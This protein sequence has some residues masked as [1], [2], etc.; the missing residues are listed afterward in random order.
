MRREKRN[1]LVAWLLFH[2]GTV[3]AL[4]QPASSQTSVATGN[5][6]IRLTV[7]INWGTSRDD[8]DSIT[9]RTEAPKR[10][11]VL[12]LTAG[13]LVDVIDWPPVSF[14]SDGDDADAIPGAADP[15]ARTWQLGTGA[16]GRVRARI[17][18]P[19]DAGVVMRAGDQVVN[20]PLVAILERPQRTPPQSDLM[21]SIE[22]LAWDSLT[23]D[24]GDA[25]RDGI[26]APGAQ[27]PV[28]VAYNIL[29][30]EP[31]DVSVRVS[32]VLR[33]SHGG[34]ALWRIEPR[35]VVAANQ[36]E[37]AKQTWNVRAPRVEGTYVLEVQASWEP[38]SAREGSR[39]SRLIRR[40]KPATFVSSSVRKVAFTVID[41]MAREAE[42]G[43]GRESEVDSIDLAK[44][45][46]YRPLAAGRSPA[47]EPGRSAWAIPPEALIEPSR[48]ERVRGWFMRNGVEASKLEPADGS[49]LAWTAV[50]LKVSHPD[51]PHRL[52]LKI[53]GGE[54]AALGVAVVEAAGGPSASSPRLLLDACASGPPIIPGG[55]PSAFNWLLWPGSSEMVLILVNRSTDAVVQ[56]GNVTVTELDELPAASTVAEPGPGGRTLGLYLSGLRSLD[57]FG[58]QAG[59]SDPFL[60]ARNLARYLR[61]C[62]ATAVVLPADL[63]DRS[64]RQSLDGQADED[65]TRPDRLETVRRVL[66]RQGYS[67]WLELGFDGF[68]SLPGLPPAGSAEALR[69]GLVRVDREGKADGPAYHPLHPQVKEAM[70]RKIQQTVASLGRRPGETPGQGTSGLL[71][72]L[73]PGPTL[74]GTPETGLDDSTFD[75]FVRETFKPETAR[76]IPGSGTTDPER[77]AVRS[78]FLAGVGRM[79]WM[80]WRTRAIAALYSELSEAAR[81][82]DPGLV[83]AVVTPGLDHGSSGSEARRID[84]AGLAPSQAW[85]SVGL[86]LPAWSS[87]PRG[88]PVL[89]GVSLSTD[90][91]ARDL[92]T[93]PDLDALV[94]A[95]PQRGLLLTIDT[96]RRRMGMTAATG[97][98]EDVAMPATSPAPGAAA[99]DAG[100]SERTGGEDPNRS[101]G[102]RNAEAKIWLTALPLGDGATADLPLGH[103]IAALDAQWMFLE[104]KAV[105]G[106]EERVRRFARVLRALP[107]RS[108]VASEQADRIAGPF[109]VTA[110]RLND[111]SQTFLEIANDSPYPV[112]VAGVLE[113]PESTV[114]EDLGRGLRLLPA[115]EAGERKLVFDLIP[116]GVAAIRVGSP[117]ARLT[118]VSSFPSDAVL[119][120]MKAHFNELSL[121][122]ARLNR[123]LAV[124]A[125]EPGN[126]GF[127]PD[128]TAAAKPGGSGATPAKDGARSVTG[129]WHVER[130]SSDTATITIDRD[131]PHSGQG[132]LKITAPAVPAA[133]ASDVFLPNVQSNLTVEAYYR[134]SEAPAKVR[135]WIEGESAGKPYIRRTEMTVGTDW[136]AR[137]VRAS[138]LPAAGLDSARLRFEMITPGV[139]WIDELHIPGEVQSKSARQNVQRTLLAALQAYREERYAD[140]A[141]LASSHWIR[142]A[143]LAAPRLAR[144]AGPA[145]KPGDAGSRSPASEPSA[146][147][148]E[149]KLR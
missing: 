19:L 110:R 26:V 119:A 55:S 106:Q 87:G 148:P 111:G 47:A 145:T 65:S 114:V 36:R 9:G 139:L 101:S 93:S 3:A 69:L 90:A 5:E 18:A 31:T 128:L 85:R 126:P 45:R 124:I 57:P 63:A 51:R 105:A 118:S 23:I 77:F 4:A 91:L 122:Y 13:R 33:P 102:L 86:D 76:D 129:G 123:G 80:T 8:A 127:E 24:L 50:G 41:P 83:L 74:L 143:S 12:E 72:R 135:V 7:E 108:G 149:R 146:L 16:S 68:E 58:A 37:P 140:F 137:S 1:V 39:L 147:S 66:A 132:S 103:A 64:A 30:P 104:E 113:A 71:I 134:A 133:V 11:H 120:G 81:A 98:A 32:A 46:N 35:E 94:A 121:Q 10:G 115:V 44:T 131:R 25:G 125:A 70:K 49:G 34:D 138:D 82:T 78:H 6:L 109:G 60:T 61:F 59:L 48:R 100:G 54:P 15:E 141:R 88:L 53:R 40:R 56:L 14:G 95:R 27:I 96:D 130:D 142:E 43:H 38:V 22:R 73:G 29:W 89:R 62:G 79:P 92:A 97:T 136:E 116:Y 21:V 84:R 42:S 99:A 28:S 52:T 17:E 2:C 75:R 107:A 112:R 67:L 20:I 144:S 117:Q